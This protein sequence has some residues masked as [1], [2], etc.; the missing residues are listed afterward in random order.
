MGWDHFMKVI[1]EIYN[2]KWQLLF[3]I[4]KEK[5]L[6]VLDFNGIKIEHIGSTSIPDI[7]SKPII[8]IMI[9]VEKDNELNS[10]INRILTLGYT[11]VQ[12]YEIFLPFR[13][14]FFKLDDPDVQMPRIIGFHDHDVDK[15]NHK[16]SFHIHM[17]KINSDFW[18][19]QLRFCNY[20]RNNCEAKKE[21]ENVKKSLAKIE[22][23][24]INEYA[25]AKSDCISKLLEEE[26][27][28][29]I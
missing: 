21:Y 26:K 28:T 22:W 27:N 8:D 25:D 24:S 6:N 2:P 16:D 20:L 7:C 23:N 10:N 12:K 13:R 3:E 11:Y 18:I 17:V 5:L 1:L 9:G 14:Y 4:E 19:D 15:G 29:K